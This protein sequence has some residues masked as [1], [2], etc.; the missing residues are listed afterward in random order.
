MSS[1][2]IPVK[3]ESRPGRK[4][5][6]LRWYIA[7]LLM[8]ATT[9]NYLDRQTLSVAVTSK[10]L[11]IPEDTYS[12]IQ[13]SWLIA[14][15]VL[16]PFAG[17]LMDWIG[18]RWGLTMAVLSWSLAEVGHAFATGVRSFAS[19]RFLLGVGESG[20]YP[21]AIKAVS[22]W[23]PARERGLATGIFNIGSGT[24][25]MIAAPLVAGI[26]MAWG[27]QAAF[28]VTGALG[29]LW[30]IAWLIVYRPLEQ[31]PW[32]DPAERAMIEAGQEPEL[33]RQAP[34]PLT[35]I[36][37]YRETWALMLCKFLSDPVWYFYLFWLPKYLKTDR[38][39][40]LKQIALF[41]WM[42]YVFA[43]IGC[44]LG[45]VCSSALSRRGLPVLRVRKIAM[46][47]FAL[48]MPAAIPAARVHSA[49]A[50]LAFICIATFGHQCW[51]VS[52]LVLPADLFPK[53]LVGRA[54][55][56]AGMCGILGASLF[57]PFVGFTV[58]WI[59]YVT[60][61]TIV[62]LLHLVATAVVLLLVGSKPPKM[63]VMAEASAA[64][65]PP[66]RPGE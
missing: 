34:V 61:F 60:I 35:A 42:P 37:A 44:V 28:V 41:A 33:D 59:G 49:Y 4:I 57:T 65:L 55:G 63:P 51:S 2:P 6:H 32:L 15:A 16:Q 11:D 45:G 40:D 64:G 30:V 13:T 23:F 21:G 19:L 5:R 7:G 36:L 9:L 10:E 24:G 50:A 18:N 14:Y 53:R 17:G 56:L 39:F 46:C 25:A 38:G 47:L 22:E 20:N 3:A 43:D 52:L 58:H 12:I 54:Y 26:I 66:P 27:W 1:G 62:G 31:H 48:L 29:L 8:L